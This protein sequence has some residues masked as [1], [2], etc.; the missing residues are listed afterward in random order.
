MKNY[1]IKVCHLLTNPSH[2]R[3]VNSVKDIIKLCSANDLLDYYQNINK[4][5]TEEPPN[6][7]VIFGNKNWVV[8]KTKPLNTWGLTSGH[9]GCYLAHIEAIKNFFN[10][11]NYDYLLIC[12]CDC[13]INANLSFF[14]EKLSL[15]CSFLEKT[16]YKL[17]SLV[18]PNFQTSFYN[19]F[20][21]DVYDANL[22]IRTQMYLIHKKQ[23]KFFEYIVSHYGWHTIDWWF[24]M[25]FEKENENFL[26]FKDSALTCQYEGNSEID[27]V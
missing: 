7:N 13:K 4:P 21:E 22:I 19:N 24:N 25:V 3:E 23:K 18:H 26:C 5:Y 20:G 9:Y 17:F 8:G 6:D 14:I 16:N 1:N 2:T 10:N 12:E 15:A 11:D 27:R